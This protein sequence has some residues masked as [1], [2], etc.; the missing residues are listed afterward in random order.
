MPGER[1]TRVATVA[2]VPLASY[3][4]LLSTTVEDPESEPASGRPIDGPDASLRLW[5][6]AG[7][8]HGLDIIR[9]VQLRKIGDALTGSERELGS[10]KVLVFIGAHR[11]I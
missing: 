8:F 7:H 10:L 1:I 2:K 5:R 6:R 4:A 11:C 9:H 3:W